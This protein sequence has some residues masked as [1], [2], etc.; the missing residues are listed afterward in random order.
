MELTQETIVQIKKEFENIC[1]KYNVT[2]VPTI[3]HQGDRTFS[4]ID[5]VPVLA[6]DTKTSE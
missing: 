6:S 2:L 4:S 5:I 1:Q 3:I